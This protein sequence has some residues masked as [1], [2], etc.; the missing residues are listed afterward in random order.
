LKYFMI[1]KKL[2]RRQTR[3]AEFLAEFDFKIVYQSE[4][5]N[6]K[7]NSLT[8]RSEDRSDENDD[9]NDR[10]KHMRQTVLSVEKID[11]RIVQE[12][13]DTK[14]L[15]LFDRV[16]TVNQENH[17][18]I[19]IRKVLQKNKKS[20]DDMLLKKFKSIENT[21]FFKKKLWVS[22]IDQLKLNIIRE[23]HDQLASEHSDVRR[24]CKYFHKWYYWS[25][26]K[27]SGN[28]TFETVISVKNSKRLETDIQNCWILCRYRINHERTLS[29]TSWLNYSKVKNLTQCWW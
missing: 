28:D 17:T 1:I 5:K 16:K 3:W 2:N 7:A 18:C 6:D 25:Q 10:N 21:L 13:N 9:S 15:F 24:T 23:I 22:E 11:S 4:K 14:E 29:W 19:E 27:Q 8:R 12:L 20:Y 26:V